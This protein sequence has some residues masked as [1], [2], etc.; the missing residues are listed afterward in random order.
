MNAIMLQGYIIVHGLRSNDF[1]YVRILGADRN[2]CILGFIQKC[3]S[4]SLE[5]SYNPCVQYQLEEKKYFKYVL[6]R[7]NLSRYMIQNKHIWGTVLMECEFQVTVAVQ[8]HILIKHKLLSLNICTKSSMLAM[9]QVNT[10]WF[11][12]LVSWSNSV[13][14][15]ETLHLCG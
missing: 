11:L 3:Y 8:N 9:W 2:T 7:I 10:Y 14:Q 15:K 13:Y 12:L 4:E 1:L 6:K 5:K